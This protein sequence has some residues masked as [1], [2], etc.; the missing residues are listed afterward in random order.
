MSVGTE[1]SKG[2][3]VVEIVAGDLEDDGVSVKGAKLF[4]VCKLVRRAP[5]SSGNVHNENGFL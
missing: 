5:A 2:W 4:E 1:G 3:N